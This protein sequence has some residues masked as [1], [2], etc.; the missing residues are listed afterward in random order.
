MWWI[1]VYQVSLLYMLSLNLERE[2]IVATKGRVKT[3]FQKT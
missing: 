3:I 1:I 2:M